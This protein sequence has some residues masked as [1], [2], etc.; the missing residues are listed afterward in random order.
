V[1]LAGA[2]I[3]PPAAPAQAVPGHV[4]VRYRATAGGAERAAAAR[5]VGAG[6]A[7]SSRLLAGTQ[8]LDLPSGA[9]PRAAAVRLARDPAVAYAEPEWTYHGAAVPSDPLYAQ[10]WAL[11]AATV[12]AAWDLETGSPGTLVAVVDSGVASGHPDLAPNL[13]TNPGETGAG[14]ESNGIDDDG[15]GFADDWQGWDWVGDDNVPG[16]AMGHGTHVAGIAAGRGDDAAGMAG[17][18][19]HA[20]ILPLRV[21][22]DHDAGSSLDIAAAFAYAAQ[23]G[24]RVVNASLLGPQSQVIDDVVRT[25]PETLFVVA[26]GNSGADVSTAPTWPCSLPY[27][28]VVCVAA[29]DAGGQLASFSNYGPSRVDIA[30]PG[31][32]LLSSQPGL[33]TVLADDFEGATH[34]F[35]AG[36]GVTD[37]H[38]SSGTHAFADSPHADYA[39]ATTTASEAT[40]DATGLSGCRVEFR[41]WLDLA[42]AGDRLRLVGTDV[43]TGT[44]DVVG[45]LT[46]PVHLDGSYRHHFLLDLQHASRLRLELTSN[47]SGRAAGATID[48]LRVRCID[49]AATPG[50][51]DFDLFSGTSMA[52]PMVTGVVALA[53]SRN[54]SLSAAAVRDALFAGAGRSPALDGRV[55]TGRLD[56]RA[57]LD[58]IPAPPP[59]A[60]ADPGQSGGAAAPDATARPPGAAPSAQRTLKGRDVGLRVRAKRT[61]AG[62]RV[63]SLG[64]HL[65][66]S[67]AATVTCAGRRCP[68]THRTLSREAR[69]TPLGAG[70]DRA[71]LRGRPALLAAGARLVV[72]VT[73][74]GRRVRLT[75]RVGAR[76]G[77]RVTRAC[78]A[79]SRATFSAC[80]A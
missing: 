26:A 44:D 3:V 39:N 10:Q 79:P 23:K 7:E 43:Q 5:R 28:N 41:L 45:Q 34:P 22:D 55:A 77:Y 37:E 51:Q 78:S 17:I 19:W 38:A 75:V 72:T 56:A 48:D 35:A 69:G 32:D 73:D 62:L 24:A 18:A 20:R 30:A 46:G 63:T 74:R 65:P 54:P 64:V 4:V 52:A 40:F 16:D 49:P 2:L 31:V 68:F 67:A 14:R 58:R 53:W 21:L 42:D 9:D 71:I 27:D 76:G 60:A 57:T 70:V 6:R 29:T 36:W 59:P 80:P 66:R 11:P 25:H 50:A 61:P 47:G 13:W 33:R 8:V 15:D 1:L 12:P